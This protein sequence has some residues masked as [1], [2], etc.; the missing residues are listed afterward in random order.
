[1][2]WI[3]FNR[4]TLN[5]CYAWVNVS[6]FINI[7]L[8]KFDLW[9]K[10]IY[11]ILLNLLHNNIFIYIYIWVQGIW[12]AWPSICQKLRP[13]CDVISLKKVYGILII[14]FTPFRYIY[15]WIYYVC[16]YLMLS[17]VCLSAMYLYIY[18]KHRINIH[19]IHGIMYACDL[20]VFDYT[21]HEISELS[22]E[23]K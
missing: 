15:I 21:L 13:Y 6:V 16:F 17:L 20:V 3:N 23:C 8:C 4:K 11:E 18:F 10:L 22:G 7:K 14:H 9:A 12:T 5:T 19:I 1:M 2:Y